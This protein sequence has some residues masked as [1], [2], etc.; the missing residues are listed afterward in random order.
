MS[1]QINESKQKAVHQSTSFSIKSASILLFAEQTKT[2][3][4]QKSMKMLPV[5]ILDGWYY[6]Y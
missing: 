4:R 2:A 1:Q 6:T 3:T 5:A